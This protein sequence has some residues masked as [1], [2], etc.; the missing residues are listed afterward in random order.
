MQSGSEGRQKDSSSSTMT[1]TDKPASKHRDATV[2]PV[3]TCQTPVQDEEPI[4]P[5]WS[6]ST[7]FKATLQAREKE[8]EGLTELAAPI[9]LSVTGAQKKGVTPARNIV[10]PTAHG[11]QPPKPTPC[12]NDEALDLTTGN[13]AQRT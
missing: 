11:C 12:G 10:P 6:P 9:D 8:A 7:A 4:P 2:P 13:G 3:H 5:S 1:L